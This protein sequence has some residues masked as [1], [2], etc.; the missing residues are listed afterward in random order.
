MRS[1]FAVRNGAAL[2]LGIVGDA[3]V[4]GDQAAG[5]KRQAQVAE[6]YAAA[7]RGCELPFDGGTKRVCVHEKR[8]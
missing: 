6:F 2:K 5:E 1:P 7:E 4:F 3:E 8:N